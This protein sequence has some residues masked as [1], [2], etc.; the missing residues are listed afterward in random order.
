VAN[1][2]PLN[3]LRDIHL[4]NAISWWPL[5]PGWYVLIVLSILACTICC[6]YIAQR[7]KQG[8]AKREA[9]ILLNIYMQNYANRQ[10][11]TQ[12]STASLNELLR[13]VALAYYPRVEVASLSGKS[14]IDFLN[15]TG[16]N[17]DFKAIEFMLLELPYK[18]DQIINIKPLFTRTKLWIQ[19]RSKPCLA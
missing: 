17:L 4:P 8:L 9:L 18:P 15:R 13:R 7:R 16:K 1:S 5:A 6:F 12:Q 14:W 19:Q 3:A 10:A 2:D 11:G